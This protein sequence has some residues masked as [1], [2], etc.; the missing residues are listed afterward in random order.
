MLTEKFGPIQ[1]GTQIELMHNVPSR[2]QIWHQIRWQIFS[3]NIFGDQT[4]LMASINHRVNHI[5]RTEFISIGQ[6]NGQLIWI[7]DYKR[8]S[9]F[10]PRSVSKC[11]EW[12]AF[13]KKIMECMN[14]CSLTRPHHF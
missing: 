11:S 2:P 7:T 1:T 12:Q 5:N 4:H 8:L 13:G 9:K 10:S 14:Q 6:L 3:L